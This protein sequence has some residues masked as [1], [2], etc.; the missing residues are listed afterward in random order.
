MSRRLTGWVLT[1]AVIAAGPAPALSRNDLDQGLGQDFQPTAMHVGAMP[2]LRDGIRSLAG[3]DRDYT[4]CLEVMTPREFAVLRGGK[5]LVQPYPTS[6]ANS[7]IRIDSGMAGDADEQLLGAID[8]SKHASSGQA[9]L[10]WPSVPSG[11]LQPEGKVQAEHVKAACG[12][13]RGLTLLAPSAREP[14]PAAAAM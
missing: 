5:V 9:M 7:K 6:N 12:I 11:E 3:D 4:D 1:A 10:P 13:P 8:R 2:L 14:R